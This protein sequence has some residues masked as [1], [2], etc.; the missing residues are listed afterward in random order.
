[1][2]H[3]R[4]LLPFAVLVALCAAAPQARAQDRFAFGF[5]TG[6][7][8]AQD[9]YASLFV[10]ST[11]INS[12]MR[13]K[14]YANGL[15]DNAADSPNRNF[16]T[17]IA[18]AV[19]RR[20]WFFFELSSVGAIPVTSVSL[21]LTNCSSSFTPACGNNGYVSPNVSELFNI[22]DFTGS[23]SNLTGGTGGVSAFNDLG[24]GSLFSSATVSNSD[25]GN[26]ITF[27]FNALGI[28]AVGAA[29][30]TS[31]V[32]GSALGSRTP[33]PNPNPVPSSSVPEPS[34]F[35]LLASGVATMMLLTRRRSRQL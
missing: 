12:Q 24:S 13:G 18:G 29:N 23:V 8:S 26:A 30:G 28:A 33:T 25:N 9:G 35:V 32:F 20:G 1:M 15:T 3:P 16:Q 21:V 17:G 2:P 34:T 31:I 11:K 7:N 10:N 5:L 19:E 6:T 22:Y 14:Y 27:T 4:Q